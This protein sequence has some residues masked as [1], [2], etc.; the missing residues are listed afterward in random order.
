MTPFR[1]ERRTRL[2]APE[3]WRRLTTWERHGQHVP[4]TQVTVVTP[5]PNRAGTRFTARTGIGAVAFDDAMEVVR[6][7]P[8]A[9]G[10]PGHCRMEKRGSAV[11]GWAA[12]EVAD[13]GPGARVVWC[14]ELRMR[15]APRLLDAPTALLGRVVFGRVV[16]RLLEP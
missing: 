5:P 1:I 13:D 15:W 6:W 12:F 3:A 7:E 4:L 2:S 8:P 11:T 9:P 14:E 16:A 10:R